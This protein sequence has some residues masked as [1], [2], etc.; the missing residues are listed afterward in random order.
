MKEYHIEES[1][2]I[3][4]KL[5]IDFDVDWWVN[6][7]IYPIKVFR[8]GGI[9]MLMNGHQLIYY[10]NKTRTTQQVGMFCDASAKTNKRKAE[11]KAI[12]WQKIS[13]Y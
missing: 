1:W 3:E 13:V 2:T 8:D 4:Y 9:L 5:S 12:R 11:K 10:S 7:S 6:M